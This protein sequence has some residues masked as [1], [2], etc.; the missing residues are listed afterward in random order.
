MQD[1]RKTYYV[2]VGAGQVLEDKE[3]A[4]FEFEIRAN[5]EE[6]NKLQELFEETSS[7]DEAAGLHFMG[8]ITVESAEDRNSDYDAQIQQ[9]Y[10]W[11]HQLGT[12]RTKRHIE[13]MGILDPQHGRDP[14]V[15]S[16]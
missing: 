13:S 16:C 15:P 6:L 9:I 14:V 2:S 11:I 12:E 10:E 5:E 3:A 4:A 8:P 7:A 1:E